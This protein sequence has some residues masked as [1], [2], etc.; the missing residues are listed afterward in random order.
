MPILPSELKSALFLSISV[1]M[2]ATNLFST[3][4]SNIF[5]FLSLLTSP[6]IKVSILSDG[7]VGCSPE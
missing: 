1:S 6:L 3:T 7:S 4:E 2:P 5:T